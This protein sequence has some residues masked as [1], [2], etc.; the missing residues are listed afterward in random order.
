MYSNAVESFVSRQRGTRIIIDLPRRDNV[1]FVSAPGQMKRQVGQNLAGR[2]VVGGKIA[3]NEDQ[4]RHRIGL[5][6]HR[7][8]VA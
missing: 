7:P 1:H 3:V 2:G 4:S 6:P 8:F 5:P